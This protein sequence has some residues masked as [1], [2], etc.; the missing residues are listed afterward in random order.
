M[1]EF[2]LRGHMNAPMKSR[3]PLVGNFHVVR[4]A[5]VGGGSCV[6][7]GAPRRGGKGRSN[8]GQGLRQ[9]GTGSLEWVTLIARGAGEGDVGHRWVIE[10]VSS[11]VTRVQRQRSRRGG[12]F[13][14]LGVR[15]RG[16]TT[17]Y[18]GTRSG[19]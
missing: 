14:G 12:T 13:C 3:Q 5:V 10:S 18:T 1:E 6:L 19:T 16:D 4:F 9:R 11:E 15:T 8:E 17:L 2:F 7:R